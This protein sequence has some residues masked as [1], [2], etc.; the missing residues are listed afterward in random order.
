MVVEIC[1]DVHPP[2]FCLDSCLA[3]LKH[4]LLEEPQL[5]VT[6]YSIPSIWKYFNSILRAELKY[7]NECH[8]QQLLHLMSRTKHCPS[9]FTHNKIGTLY[10]QTKFLHW[11]FS[12]VSKWVKVIFSSDPLP[13]LTLLSEISGKKK[14]KLVLQNL[15]ASTENW[16]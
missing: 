5:F 2:P 8:G 9:K 10:M 1:S 14:G 13:S 4:V 15:D 6:K 7:K 16:L 12:L 11:P 3:T